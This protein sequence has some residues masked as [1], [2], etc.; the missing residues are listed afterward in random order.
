M[1]VFKRVR[2]L[3]VLLD[4][5]TNVGSITETLARKVQLKRHA[6]ADKRLDIQGI[7]EQKVSRNARAEVKV[8]LGWRMVYSL[9]VWIASPVLIWCSAP[10]L[11]SRRV[12]DSACTSV[13]HACSMRSRHQDQNVKTVGGNNK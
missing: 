9:E 6:L 5:G 3:W 11:W 12:Y 13:S 10:T 4:A 7:G 8:V 2:R 1:N